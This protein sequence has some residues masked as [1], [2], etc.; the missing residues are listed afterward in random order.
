MDGFSFI[1]VEEIAVLSSR[2]PYSTEL[3]VVSFCGGWPR[4]D[5]R[6]WRTESDGKHP[7]RGAQL[8]RA[9]MRVLR[10]KLNEMEL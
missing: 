8:S 4:F 7:G 9:E 5:I 1:I 6:R 10:D 3:N 2:P